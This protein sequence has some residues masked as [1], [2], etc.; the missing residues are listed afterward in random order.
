[1]N[2]WLK[3]IHTTT[4]FLKVIL[5]SESFKR[6]NY[7]THFVEKFMKNKKDKGER[8]K[9]MAGNFS[10]MIGERMFCKRK[11]WFGE[12]SEDYSLFQP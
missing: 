10:P 7:S 8:K 3:G 1:M 2:W 12:K 6:G 5:E 11:A 4:D 9:V